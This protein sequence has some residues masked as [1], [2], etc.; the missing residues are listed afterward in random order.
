[1]THHTWSVNVVQQDVQLAA[2]R[3][4]DNQ[5]QKLTVAVALAAAVGERAGNCLQHLQ[6]TNHAATVVLEKETGMSSG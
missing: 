5:R 4:A 6:T 2:G 3:L 1:M